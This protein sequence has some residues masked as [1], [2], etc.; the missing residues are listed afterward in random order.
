MVR[1]A[2]PKR[3]KAAVLEYA[4]NE[5]L[6]NPPPQPFELV[7]LGYID[8]FGVEAVMGRPVLSAGEIRG[9][10]T[11]RNIYDAFHSRK[12]S[13]DWVKWAKDHPHYAAILAE[14]E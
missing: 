8:R 1:R 7:L 10:M 12:S 2:S 5:H 3:L 4:E 13:D 14:V 6:D 11:A 9:M